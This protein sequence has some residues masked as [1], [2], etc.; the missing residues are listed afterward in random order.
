MALAEIRQGLLFFPSFQFSIHCFQLISHGA[1]IVTKKDIG[2]A[3]AEFEIANLTMSGL[4]LR[5]VKVYE[6]NQS[7]VCKRFIR[8]ITVS[9]SYTL[10]TS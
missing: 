3:M 1:Q 5:Y 6:G 2:P 9:D 4:K 7:C 8:C 10:K